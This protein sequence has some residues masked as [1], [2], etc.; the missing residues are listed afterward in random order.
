MTLNDLLQQGN[1]GRELERKPVLQSLQ[2]LALSGARQLFAGTVLS[3][4]RRFDTIESV[5][6]ENSLA[7]IAVN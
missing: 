4:H 1:D 3:S 2:M 6:S 5:I 7:V